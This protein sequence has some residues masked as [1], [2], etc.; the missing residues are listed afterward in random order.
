[1]LAHLENKVNAHFGWGMLCFRP[2][3]LD[4]YRRK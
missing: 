3:S 2:Y 4:W 1:M